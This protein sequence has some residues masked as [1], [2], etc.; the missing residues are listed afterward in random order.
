[1]GVQDLGRGDQ[2]C[3][4]V[5]DEC[6]GPGMRG[7]WGHQGKGQMPRV[8]DWGTRVLWKWMDMDVLGQRTGAQDQGHGGAGMGAQHGDWGMMGGG[9][10]QSDGWVHGLGDKG[11]GASQGDGWLPRDRGT[12]VVL[13]CGM[14][15]QDGNWGS[16]GARSS[17]P[18]GAVGPVPAPSQGSWPPAEEIVQLNGGSGVAWAEE[19]EER[20][21][22]WAMRHSAWY[23]A[24]ALRPGCQV[25]AGHGGRGTMAAAPRGAAGATSLPCPGLL[26]GRLRAHLPPARRGGGDQ[27][28]P[29]GLRPHRSAGPRPPR[30]GGGQLGGA[31]ILPA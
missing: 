27:A 18:G 5:R 31:T 16:P 24:L 9:G 26:H 22:L 1:M 25:R 23:A 19:P 17:C 6:L 21:R 7:P 15:A 3:P 11:P 20:G 8:G 28:G 12:S 13:G 4:G 29:A 14:D 30:A 2:A 10:H